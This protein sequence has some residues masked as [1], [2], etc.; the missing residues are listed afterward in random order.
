LCLSDEPSVTVTD[1]PSL[2]GK[3]KYDDP[4]YVRPDSYE[5]EPFT[6]SVVRQNFHNEV[7]KFLIK[8]I[9]LELTGAYAYR[10][11]SFHF[12]SCDVALPGFAKFFMDCADVELGCALEL[13]KIM[14]RRGGRVVLFDVKKP[15][16]RNWGNGSDAMLAALELQKNLIENLHEFHKLCIK[17]VDPHMEKRVNDYICNS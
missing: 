7:E 6:N 2:I 9:N 5:V 4:D 11:M 8:L 1:K 16:L 3:G 12:D 13:G 14:N 15:S 17:H 10:S